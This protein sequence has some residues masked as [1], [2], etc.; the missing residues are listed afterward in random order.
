M[1]ITPASSEE[2]IVVQEP[3]DL[4]P[5][6]PDEA[7]LQEINLSTQVSEEVDGGVPSVERK[8][9]HPLPQALLSTLSSERS[10]SG[11]PESSNGHVPAKAS[12]EFVRAVRCTI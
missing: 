4:P 6:N 5:A 1:P 8:E 10:A 2:F 9:P 3:T 11:T 12:P 7:L